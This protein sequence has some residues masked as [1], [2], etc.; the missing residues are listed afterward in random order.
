MRHVGQKPN[1][2]MVRMLVTTTDTIE[3][4]QMAEALG[5]YE[6]TPEPAV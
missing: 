4:T 2:E 1:R 5:R 3:D 6:R